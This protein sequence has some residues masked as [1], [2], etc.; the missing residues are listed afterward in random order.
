M[1]RKNPTQQPVQKRCAI[2][3]PES[4]F[5]LE[6]RRPKQSM[7]SACVLLFSYKI[8]GYPYNKC[9]YLT[10]DIYLEW[11]T[12]MKIIREPIENKNRIFTKQ[13]EAY[14]KDVE[15]AFSV[16]QFWQAIV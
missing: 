3:N 16:L 7:A 12:F 1:A 14:R 15:R 2:C 13:Q 9:Y 4:K 10:D 11:Y 6:M 8:N 5:R